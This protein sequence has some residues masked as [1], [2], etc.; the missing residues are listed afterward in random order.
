MRTDFKN[1]MLLPASIRFR[2]DLTGSNP[3]S[4]ENSRQQKENL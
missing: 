2:L 4:F 1:Y 3:T